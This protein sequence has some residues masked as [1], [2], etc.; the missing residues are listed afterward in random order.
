MGVNMVKLRMQESPKATNR[1][2]ERWLLPLLIWTLPLVTLGL[3]THSWLPP[4]ASD[5]GKG[6]DRMLHYLV[7]SVGG[8]YVVAHGIF[9]YFLWRFSR[10]DKVTMRLPSKKAERRWSL[11]P[12][13]V[14]LVV[15][16]GGVILLGLP[17][18]GKYYAAP[19]SDALTVEVTAEQ[20]AWNVRY[21]GADGQF[22]R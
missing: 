5:H 16:E 6:I 17:V 4:I 21:T 7:F 15:A 22:G 18:W 8:L 12:M 14:M 19:P 9:G 13:A 11:I 20:F 2:C 10:Q 1:T 3:A